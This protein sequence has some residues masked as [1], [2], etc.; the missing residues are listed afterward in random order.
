M[1]PPSA[2]DRAVMPRRRGVREQTRVRRASRKRRRL[3]R[4]DRGRS[5]PE[6]TPASMIL[7][8]VRT[9]RS[10]DSS[11]E[12]QE[13]G[14]RGSSPRIS[15]T[16]GSSGVHSMPIKVARARHFV[17]SRASS[18]GRR[19]SR[20]SQNA[21]KSANAL[22]ERHSLSPGTAAAASRWKYRRARMSA[23]VVL[24][25]R[26]RR[27]VRVLPPRCGQPAVPPVRKRE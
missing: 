18:A 17:G 19:P 1:S 15:R 23:S 16:T 14:N 8:S 13:S 5:S 2:V 10:S 9:N 25:Y 6:A 21:G 24:A 22:R 7:W 11:R 26:A 20:A 12:R 3:L 4:V 27:T